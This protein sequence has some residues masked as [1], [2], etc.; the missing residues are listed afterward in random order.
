MV[1]ENMVYSQDHMQKE[2]PKPQL[3]HLKEE[4]YKSPN[5]S[6]IVTFLI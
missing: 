2:V 1:G 5:E 6:Q 4:F 3:F